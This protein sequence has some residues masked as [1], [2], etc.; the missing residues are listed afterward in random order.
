MVKY[1]RNNY[2]DLE[3]NEKVGKKNCCLCCNKKNKNGTDK[4][5]LNKDFK[6]HIKGRTHLINLNKW[7]LNNFDDLDEIFKKYNE[8]IIINHLKIYLNKIKYNK[9]MEELLEQLIRY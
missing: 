8:E 5:Y 7:K 1:I 3:Y 9:V 4:L 2:D 6:I